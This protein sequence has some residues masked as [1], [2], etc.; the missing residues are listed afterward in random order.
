VLTVPRGPPGPVLHPGL[1][2]LDLIAPRSGIR[3]LRTS[4]CRQGNGDRE[5]EAATRQRR[6]PQQ[7]RPTSTPETREHGQAPRLDGTGRDAPRQSAC[8]LKPAR[9]VPYRLTRPSAD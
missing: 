8:P 2:S 7:G 1:H 3:H 5:A 9:A 4:R 6:L